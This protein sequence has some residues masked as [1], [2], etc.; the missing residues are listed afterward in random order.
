MA[1]PRRWE[2][3]RSAPVRADAEGLFVPFEDLPE[4]AIGDRVALSDDAGGVDRSGTIVAA[5]EHDGA[6]FHRIELD[7]LDAPPE[8]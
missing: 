8:A 7:E 1:E 6:K 5:S 2:L 4:A 3:Q